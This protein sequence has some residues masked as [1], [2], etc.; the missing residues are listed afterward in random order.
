[1]SN[2]SSIENLFRTSG[3]LKE[4]VKERLFFLLEKLALPLKIFLERLINKAY[5]DII[6]RNY[7]NEIPRENHED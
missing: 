1:M 3:F 2:K 5:K 4:E 6:E 7:L